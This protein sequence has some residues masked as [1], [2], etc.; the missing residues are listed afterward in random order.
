MTFTEQELEQIEQLA[1]LY[2]PVTDIATVM[3]VRPEELRKQIRIKDDPVAIAYQKGKTMRKVQLRKQ[4][5]QLAQVGSPL[6]L[7]N[8]RLAL[9]DMEDD[10]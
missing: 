8:A 7:E 4:E 3:G 10:E 6:A 1:S 9:I 2:L 5:I